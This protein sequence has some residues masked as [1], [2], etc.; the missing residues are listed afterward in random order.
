VKTRIF[1]KALLIIALLVCCTTISAYAQKLGYINSQKI[2]AS[3]KEAQDAQERLDKISQDWETEARAKQKTFQDLGEQI[4][5]QK[6]LLS[7]ERLREKQQE[8]QSLYNEIQKFQAEKFG[9]GGE[10]YK[11]QEEIMQPVID[12]VNA[13]IKKIGDEQGFDYIFDAVG[14]NIVYASPKQPDL[15]DQ[16]LQELEKGLETT[17]ST[18]PGSN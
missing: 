15:T 10:L 9:Q 11:K 6:L 1:S 12:K 3:Y 7:E 5:S 18:K 16:L 13:A 2:M 8:L 14:Q 4:E 17:S